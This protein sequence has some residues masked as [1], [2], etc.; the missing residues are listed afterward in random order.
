MVLTI[1]TYI[2]SSQYTHTYGTHITHTYSTHVSQSFRYAKRRCYRHK[3]EGVAD[4][5][6][7]H[8]IWPKGCELCMCMCVYLHVRIYLCMYLRM[9]RVV[10][11]DIKLKV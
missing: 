7:N 9:L 3:I 2:W 4:E 10:A 5:V 8:D 11:I 1:H 6:K